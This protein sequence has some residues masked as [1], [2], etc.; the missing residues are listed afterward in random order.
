MDLGEDLLRKGLSLARLDYLT[1]E[2]R[3]VS[4]CD[5]VLEDGYMTIIMPTDWCLLD[6]RFVVMVSR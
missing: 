2:F 6:G 1:I 5:N 4:R 3:T